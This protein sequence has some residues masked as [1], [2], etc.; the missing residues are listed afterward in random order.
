MVRCK[1]SMMQVASTTVAT[2]GQQW[3]L[4]ERPK[5][6]SSSIPPGD[7]VED[8]DI[9]KGAVRPVKRISTFQV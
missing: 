4:A 1:C 5:P 7:L 9:R 3:E 2:V 6:A 8:H